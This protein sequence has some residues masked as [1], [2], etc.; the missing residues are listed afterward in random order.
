M[1]VSVLL[2][3][4]LLSAAA[5]TPAGDIA[6]L[7]DAV[8]D[9]ELAQGKATGAPSLSGARAPALESAG[10]AST[11]QGRSFGVGLQL[12]YPTALTLKYMLRADRGLVGGVGG[13]SG[14]AYD[15][16]AFSVHVDYVYHPQVLTR[17]DTFVV[18]WYVG[19]GAN[20]VIF[21]NARQRSFLP[22]VSYFYYPTTVWL[23][24]RVPLGVTLAM[25]QQPVEIYLEATPMVLVFPG[26][27]FGLGASIGARF[28]L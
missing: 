11:P 19:G 1:E 2:T 3:A 7:V 27:S 25:E 24:G 22:G 13:F 15:V 18:T 4:L 5:P 6:E 20:V 21:S 14:F 8:V 26:F 12:G 10:S 23:A 28:Y 16:G 17:G 9:L